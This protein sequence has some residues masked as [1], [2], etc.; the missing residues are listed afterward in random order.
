IDDISRGEGEVSL[1][2]AFTREHQQIDAGIEEYLAGSS[3]THEP[4][5][6]AQPLLTAME[7]LRRHIYLE[8]EIVFPPLPQGPLM[9]PLMVMCREHG[10]LWR[11]M[12]D[13]SVI[14]EGDSAD[15]A[16]METACA[17]LLVLLDT[18]NSKEE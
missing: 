12:E 17:E 3:S 16:R 6:R 13:L 7:A 2:A 5:R 11:R 4:M 9:M 10:E 8:E 1:A 15:T 14:L 18:H